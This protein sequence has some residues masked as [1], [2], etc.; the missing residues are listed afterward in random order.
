MYLF[1]NM[2]S[3]NK[4]NRTTFDLAHATLKAQR[5]WRYTTWQ[6]HAK[7][8]AVICEHLFERRWE[9]M[10]GVGDNLLKFFSVTD[11]LDASSGLTWVLMIQSQCKM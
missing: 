11:E 9:N 7:D 2:K 5:Y 4:W 3:T 1:L 8:V 6:V 10:W